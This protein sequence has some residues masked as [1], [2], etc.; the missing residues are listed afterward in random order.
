MKNQ[1]IADKADFYVAPDGSDDAPGTL[2]HP[3][4]TV[5]RARQAVRDIPGRSQR[6]AIHVL[7]RG[8]VYYL[9]EPLVFGLEDSLAGGGTTTYAAYPGERPVLSGGIPIN[10]WR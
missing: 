4:A 5:A 1:E 2:Q 9:S 10:N 8:G 3:F 6:D 7:L